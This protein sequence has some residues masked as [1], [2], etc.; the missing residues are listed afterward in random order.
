MDV[1]ATVTAVLESAKHRKLFWVFLD[2]QMTAG[3][4]EGERR[5]SSPGLFPNAFCRGS[6]AVSGHCGA[7]LSLA[8]QNLGAEHLSS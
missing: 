4:L 3:P 7:F 5:H 8:T 2:H 1:A 6:A